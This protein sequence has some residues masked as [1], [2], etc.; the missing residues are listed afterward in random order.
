MGASVLGKAKND[1]S[2]GSGGGSCKPPM[3]S[4]AMPWSTHGSILNNFA[5]FLVQYPKMVIVT[6]N[7]G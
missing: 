2:S 1:E 6:V 7:I 5:V 4:K 3:R